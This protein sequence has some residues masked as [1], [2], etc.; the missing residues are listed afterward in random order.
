MQITENETLARIIRHLA[1]LGWTAV[2]LYDGGD[3][4][5][6]L[7]GMPVDQVVTESRGTDDCHLRVEKE[8]NQGTLY[9]VWGNSPFELIADLTTRWGL[10]DDVDAALAS[11][12]PLWPDDSQLVLEEA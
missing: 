7:R 2:D 3:E 1:K 12:W 6:D 10:E 9:I 4:P 8:G 11:I 5:I